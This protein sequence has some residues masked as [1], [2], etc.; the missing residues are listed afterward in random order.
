VYNFTSQFPEIA[1]KLTKNFGGYF[2]PRPVGFSFTCIETP[3]KRFKDHHVV[4]YTLF[5]YE[6][7]RKIQESS[8]LAYT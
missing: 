4:L 6:Q 7:K 3:K 1:K 5:G 2:L 8:R